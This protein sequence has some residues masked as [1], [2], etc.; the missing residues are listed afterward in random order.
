MKSGK[1]SGQLLIR[2][3]ADPYV[4]EAKVLLK[5]GNWSASEMVEKAEKRL[6]FKQIL[7]LSVQSQWTKWCSC[8]CIDLLWKTLLAMPQQLLTFCFGA[9]YNTLP[10]P[11]NLHRWHINPEASSLLCKKQVRTTAHVL[12]ARTVA[13]QQGRFTFR[14]DSVLSA[15]IVALESFLSSK[16]C[17]NAQSN[18]SIK[19]VK[20]GA[21]LSKYTKKLHSGLLH[22][23]TDLKLLSDLG[24]KLVFPSFITIT[25]LRS[26]IVLFSTSI[27]TVIILELTCPCEEN[28]EE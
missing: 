15:L 11:S 26:D 5:S 16:K 17:I 6:N 8:V 25:C 10:S 1:V 28:M 21:K 18:N 3:S 14:H 27:K 12:G 19:F 7:G 20:A 23:T 2:E 13:L 24:D 9:T 22:L 4:S